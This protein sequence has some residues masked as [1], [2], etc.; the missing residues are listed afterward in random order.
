M[1]KIPRKL[2]SNLSAFF[3]SGDGK[4]SKESLA[5]LIQNAILADDFESISNLIDSAKEVSS[6][7]Y[8]IRKILDCP[9]D[10]SAKRPLHLCVIY[11]R[12]SMI[13]QLIEQGANLNS[14]D[15]Q[16]RTPLDFALQKYSE[17]KSDPEIQKI[18]ELL[19]S[20]QDQ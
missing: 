9:L 4:K 13:E 12:T 16:N 18:L 11:R 7:P 8:A 6:S 5:S 17:E 20:K 2:F 15:T 10:I 1:A 3:S 14:L 19:S